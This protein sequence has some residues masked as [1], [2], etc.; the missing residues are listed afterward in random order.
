MKK[1]YL[2]TLLVLSL[3]LVSNVSAVNQQNGQ[4]QNGNQ[5]QLNQLLPQ[6]AIDACS[7]LNEDDVCSFEGQMGSET[8]T[9]VFAPD[10]EV[11]S[12]YSEAQGEGQL[13][14][15]Q[16]GNQSQVGQGM[17]QEGSQNSEPEFQ[18]GEQGMNQGENSQGQSQDNGNGTQTRSRVADAVQAMLQIAENNSGVGDQIRTIA[19]TQSQ[20][21]E[22]IEL[23]LEKINNRSRFTRLFIGADYSGISDVESL[24]EENADKI[25]QLEEIKS[26]LSEEDQL[27][28]ETHIAS[29]QA[30]NLEIQEDLDSSQTGF[31]LLGWLF[32]AFSN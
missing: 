18:G 22:E 19:Q 32:K 9:C 25:S 7:D 24:L 30:I 21:Q 17:D 27:L 20:N 15:N 3:F 10:T 29:I 28:L 13:M 14:V 4:Q 2:V 23:K 1:Q 11:L 6:E 26:E 16:N 5:P 12:C 8:G 31:S